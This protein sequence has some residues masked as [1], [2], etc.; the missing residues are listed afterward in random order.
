MHMPHAHATC[1]CTCTCIGNELVEHTCT[2]CTDLTCEHVDVLPTLFRIPRPAFTQAEPRTVRHRS[3][4]H[5]EASLILYSSDGTTL[6]AGVGDSALCELHTHF[7][8]ES[9][10]VEAKDATSH[11]G[12]TPARAEF[13]CAA[14]LRLRGLH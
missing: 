1:T 11:E 2:T 6:F 12:T 4:T 14:R 13:K 10:R 7:D 5:G 8:I 3:L 9:S